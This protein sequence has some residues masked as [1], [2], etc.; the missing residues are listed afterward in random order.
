MKVIHYITNLTEKAGPIAASVWKMMASVSR[1]AETHLL[2]CVPLSEEYVGML[3]ERYSIT[4]HYVKPVQD[5]NPLEFRTFEANVNKVLKNLKPDVVHVHGTWD[6]MAAMAEWK[7]R[8]EGYVTVV[9]P[10]RGLSQEIINIDFWKKKLPRLIAYQAWMV[11]KSVTVIAESEREKEGI[12]ALGLKKRIEVMPDDEAAMRDALLRAYRKALDSTYFRYLTKGETHF[13]NATVRK[14]VVDGKTEVAVPN[15][16]GLSFRRIYFYAYDEDVT[17]LM[18]EGARKMQINMPPV[19]DVEN[20]PRYRNKKAKERKRLA[21][22]AVEMLAAANAITMKRMTLRQYVNLY[23]MFRYEDFDEDA[24][25]EELKRRKLKR[26]TK[27]M[28]KRMAEMFGMTS[29]YDIF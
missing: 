5:R 18:L 26:F 25:A 11:R 16:Q 14:A 15:L 19:L 6:F 7:A 3:Q 1:V 17:D 21:G 9:S 23:Q 28:Q 8:H 27:K 24:A 10:H 13:V 29:G 22:S 4:V 12:L 20:V 2:T